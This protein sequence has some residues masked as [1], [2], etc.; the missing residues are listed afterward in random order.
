[1]PVFKQKKDSLEA[2]REVKIQLAKD[3]QALI[4]I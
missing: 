3:L 4:G 2:V 1:M